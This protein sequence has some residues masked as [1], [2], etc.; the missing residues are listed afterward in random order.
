MIIENEISFIETE[1]TTFNEK[2][3]ALM[4]EIKVNEFILRE[5]RR[6]KMLTTNK[7]KT[8]MM[9]E[10]I[11]EL[12]ER[13]NKIIKIFN[14]D[15]INTISDRYVTPDEAKRIIKNEFGEDIT[16]DELISEKIIEKIW[17]LKLKRRTVLIGALASLLVYGAINPSEIERGLRGLEIIESVKDNNE[18]KKPEGVIEKVEKKIKEAGIEIKEAIKIQKEKA[19][20]SSNMK[21]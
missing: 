13:N 3:E 21:K 1:K 11:D 9:M 7:N 18:E 15:N 6:R 17:T 2:K 14:D 4:N 19:G 10:R 8:R 12:T 20:K 5:L 16:A